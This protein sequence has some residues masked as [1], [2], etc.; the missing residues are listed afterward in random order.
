MVESFKSHLFK[1]KLVKYNLL[2]IRGGRAEHACLCGWSC[3][4]WAP[5][6]LRIVQCQGVSSNND[7]CPAEV[8]LRPT[9]LYRTAMN[10]K[11]LIYRIATKSKRNRS[12][13]N[14]TSGFSW[15]VG[16]GRS[17]RGLIFEAF[18]K[19]L[20]AVCHNS[21][22]ATLLSDSDLVMYFSTLPAPSSSAPCILALPP[23]LRGGVS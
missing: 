16:K 8:W 14:G 12:H 23:H 9:K 18:P 20:V 3:E 10:F 19:N 7:C 21:Q 2:K 15:R 4:V 22:S 6:Y 1:S 11:R 17:L 13:Q 5:F